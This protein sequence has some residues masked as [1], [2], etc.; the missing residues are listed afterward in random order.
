MAPTAFILGLVRGGGSQSNLFSCFFEVTSWLEPQASLG[1]L[2]VS[3]QLY[4]GYIA[5]QFQHA[6]GAAVS[7]DG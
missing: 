7:L 3:Q 2:L 1:L 5:P 6:A 4:Y